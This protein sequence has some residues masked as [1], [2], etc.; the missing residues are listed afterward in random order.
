MDSNVINE[1]I[2]FVRKEILQLYKIVLGKQY[3]RVIAEKLVDKYISVRYF[4]ESKFLKSKDFIERISKE[5]MSLIKPYLET[6]SGEIAKTI[7]ALFGYLFYFDD[8]YLIEDERAFM[9][10]FF[11]DENIKVEFNSEKEKEVK[12]FIRQ[13]NRN[14]ESFHKVFSS[15]QFSLNER[16][17]KKNLYTLKLNQSI[18]ISPLFS[19]YAIEK[20]FNTGVVNED[21]MFVL[22]SMSSE[23]L[24]QNAIS[25][26][27]SRYYVVE[28]PNTLFLKE[29]KIERFFGY[30]DNELSK[31]QLIINIRYE[32][33]IS[34]GKIINSFISRGFS[35]CITIGEYFDENFSNFILFTHVFLYDDSQFYDMIM[36][37]KESISAQLIIL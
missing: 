36:E 30:I 22:L 29:K 19:D 4:N 20:S 3:D 2:K 33:Y 8:C 28:F 9:D 5:L 27:F 10:I 37:N 6:E 13:F 11:T 16:R 23:L 34:N 32:D 7:Y 24:L 25:L 31:K 14:K 1:Y 15:N 17:L 35:F 18:R 26:D 21:K 12:K